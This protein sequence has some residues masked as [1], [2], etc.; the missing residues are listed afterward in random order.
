MQR[1]KASLGVTECL[2]RTTSYSSREYHSARYVLR[3]SSSFL[4]F[5]ADSC[6]FLL[7]FILTSPFPPDLLFHPPTPPFFHPPLYPLAF[8]NL[9][10][11]SLPFAFLFFS[12]RPA[13]PYT[14]KMQT[15]VASPI[16]RTTSNGKHCP[17]TLRLKLCS[18]EIRR[19]EKKS[20]PKISTTMAVRT[21]SCECT[22]VYLL[23]CAEFIDLCWIQRASLHVLLQMCPSA[24]SH[25]LA[26]MC[27]WWRV[28][29]YAYVTSVCIQAHLSIRTYSCVRTDVV[30]EFCSRE[31]Q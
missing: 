23:M 22:H 29:T 4:S 10:H 13:T 5:S 14:R 6:L 19:R 16:R 28:C 8:L 11:S 18:M 20:L 1:V 26:L 27:R 2:L 25:V 9:D 3:P 31:Y 12:F 7:P 15:S 24:C 21:Y 30:K 17:S